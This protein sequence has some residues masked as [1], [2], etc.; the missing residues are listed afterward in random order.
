[1]YAKDINDKKNTFEKNMN[2]KEIIDIHNMYIIEQKIIKKEIEKKQKKEIAD[3]IYNHGMVKFNDDHSFSV[4]EFDLD[5]DLKLR[6]ESMLSFTDK[7][8]IH[9][10]HDCLKYYVSQGKDPTDPNGG[11]L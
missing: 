5:D 1:M 6:N 10:M 3:K 8:A 2:Y 11:M 7:V 9:D 4:T